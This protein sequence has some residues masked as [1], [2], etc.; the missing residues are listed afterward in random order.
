MLVVVYRQGSSVGVAAIKARVLGGYSCLWVVVLVVVYRQ[1][2][3][4]AEV[5]DRAVQHL[6]AMRLVVSGSAALPQGLFR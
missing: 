1:G 5:L 3:L 2:G 4:E 6:R